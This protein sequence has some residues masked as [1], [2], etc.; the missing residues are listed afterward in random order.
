MSIV[1]QTE[2][3]KQLRFVQLFLLGLSIDLIVD[4]VTKT[5]S[6][7]FTR[8]SETLFCFI[9]TEPWSSRPHEVYW[10]WQGQCLCPA[11][12]EV[13]KMRQ[14]QTNARTHAHTHTDNLS[15]PACRKQLMETWPVN[16][17]NSQEFGIPAAVIIWAH[18]LPALSGFSQPAQWWLNGS[19]PMRRHVFLTSLTKR[20]M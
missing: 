6:L 17:Y 11:P 12:E 8:T 19:R 14:T 3:Q 5:I 16:T 18:T 20:G 9:R 2:R 1:S 13:T 10:S 4:S 7:T 15:V